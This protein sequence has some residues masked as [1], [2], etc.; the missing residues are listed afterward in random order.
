[1]AAD[2]SFSRIEQRGFTT[3]APEFG[4]SVHVELAGL[5]PVRDYFYRFR[6]DG[7]LSP[8]GRTRTAP[9]PGSLAAPLTM[10]FVSCSNFEHGWFTAYR[11][12]AEEQPDL[13]LHLGDYQYEYAAGVYE[14]DSASVRAHLG[15]EA[16]TLANYRQ[17]YAQYKTDPDLQAAHAAAPWLAVFDDHEVDDNWADEVPSTPQ[18]GFLARR[19][20][21]LQAYYENMP[22]RRASMPHDIHMQL[23]RRVHWGTLATFHMLDT[24]Q[25]RDD[26]LCGDKVSA[27]PERTD[28]ARSLTGAEQERWLLDGFQ[29]SRARWDLVGQQVFFSQRDLAPGSDCAFNPDAWDGYAANRDRIVAGLVN[30][31]VRNAVM[32]TGD[33]HSHWAAEVR[34]NFDDPS[35]RQVATEFVT[36]SI[37]SGG[38]GS[39]TRDDIEAVLPKNP[40][41]RYFSNRRGYVRTRIA[42][43]E[44]RAD[45]RVLPYVSRPDAPAYTGATFV[46]TDRASVLDAV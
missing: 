19:A 28:P 41:I 7:H 12:L 44:L 46:L 38:D 6:V 10:C 32:L 31:P 25:Y 39:D 43:G 27:C 17:R 13:V 3:A 36:T 42:H 4:H 20:A 22:L 26:Q 16:R 2:E 1:V 15:P 21:A 37:S 29:R 35:S 9:E 33:V 45:F 14:A 8:A 5:R 11:R 18:P 24:R 40:H 23:Y 34:E 30:S